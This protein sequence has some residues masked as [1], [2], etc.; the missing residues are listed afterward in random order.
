MVSIKSFNSIQV[1]QIKKKSRLMPKKI[2]PG[3]GPCFLFTFYSDSWSQNAYTLSLYKTLGP[4][5]NQPN[6]WTY[7]THIS[8]YKGPI[9]Q[10][11]CCIY[12][13]R[14]G[15]FYRT[16]R[17][18]TL[19]TQDQGLHNSEGPRGQALY[20]LYFVRFTG[21][22]STLWIEPILRKAVGAL[23]Q[24]ETELSFRLIPFL[25]KITSSLTVLERGFVWD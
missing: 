6:E 2:Q 18:R 1:Y 19:W 7:W 24:G 12:C 22:Y 15:D 14:F 11:F 23:L 10:N 3:K 20:C 13:V 16:I 21:S 9:G 25:A 4:W 17:G 8:P 5:K